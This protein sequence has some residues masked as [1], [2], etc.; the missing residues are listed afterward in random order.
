MKKSLQILATA[1]L[2]AAGSMTASAERYYETVGDGVTA[3]NIQPG[4]QY[5]FQ[6]GQSVLEGKYAFLSG[7]YFNFS[8]NLVPTCLYTFEAT[9]ETVE[10][11]KVYYIKDKDGNYVYAPGNDNF[12]GTSVSRAWKVCVK[13]AAVYDSEYTYSVTGDDGEP[14]GLHGNGRLCGRSQGKWLSLRP[15]RGNLLRR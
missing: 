1:A 8:V 9:G 6:G 12:Y 7:S 3:D 11:S 4:V 15:F 14:R 2:L 5:A 10:G 13:D